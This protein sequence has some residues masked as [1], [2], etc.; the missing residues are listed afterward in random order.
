MNFI[1]GNYAPFCGHTWVSRSTDV[2]K[3]YALRSLGGEGSSL[4]VYDASKVLA[5]GADAVMPVEG[6]PCLGEF[7]TPGQHSCHITLLG[8][9]AVLADYTSGTLSVF[10][11]DAEGLP[12]SEAKLIHFPFRESKAHG[13]NRTVFDPSRQ[14]SGHVHSS[15]L[16][17]DGQQLVVVDLGNDCLY[18]FKVSNG[19]ISEE[20]ETVALP[21]GCG[22]RHC[23]FGK[24]RLYVATELSDEVLVYSWPEKKML[25]R[26]LVNSSG[27]RGGGHVMLSPDGRYLYVSSR[28]Q[29][30]GIA[31]LRVAA[32]GLL[33]SVGYQKTGAHPRHFCISPDGSML[34]VACRDSDII[35]IFS[36]D[37]QT[38][39]LTKVSEKLSAKPVFVDFNN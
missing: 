11:L 2:E 34:A 19:R 33:T 3:I 28:L 21:D 22:P 27:P 20:Y 32:D 38:G 6:M 15:W 7:R 8:K 16:S 17:G 18:I 37:I 36:R 23:A 24:D 26:V 10:E 35:E 29:N 4:L 30:D 9:Q 25:Q 31:I 12:C 39:L 5:E 14:A 13:G 1:I